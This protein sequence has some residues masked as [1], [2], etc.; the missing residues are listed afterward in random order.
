VARGIV[1]RRPRPLQD[2]ANSSVMRSLVAA[3]L[4]VVGSPAIAQQP[5]IAPQSP[6]TFPIPADMREDWPG[7]TLNEA[8]KGLLQ[9]AMAAEIRNQ[10]D[11]DPDSGKKYSFGSIDTADVALGKLGKGV[12]VK[13]SGSFSCGTGGC[14]IYV[15][16]R[17]KEGYR[18]VLRTFGWAFAAVGSKATTPTLVIASNLGGGH[19]VLTL[20]RYAG[21]AFTDQACD[22]LTWKDVSA[23][24]SWWDTSQVNVQS[25]S[26][27]RRNGYR[28]RPARN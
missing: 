4:L 23:T 21:E 17:E 18:K 3:V 10:G 2:V 11:E 25:C 5:P 8:D 22:V 7:A 9:R 28:P 13:M 14:P 1:G 20:Y 24:N 15:Y 16:V 27:R 6:P 19:M 12:I 26:W